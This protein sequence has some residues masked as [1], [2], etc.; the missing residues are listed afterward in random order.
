MNTIE[1]AWMVPST[2][3]LW[4]DPC[5]LIMDLFGLP[6]ERY[7]TTITHKSIQFHFNEDKDAFMCRLLISEYQ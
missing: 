6:G 1:L 4:T 7:T 5:T 2:Q 3:K